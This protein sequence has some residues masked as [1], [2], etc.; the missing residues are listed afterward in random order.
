MNA[1]GG[2]H[3]Q[4]EPKAR[5]N[6]ASALIRVSL[7]EAIQ[8]IAAIE[9]RLHAHVLVEAVDVPKIGPDE[10]GLDAVGWYAGGIQELTVGRTG[11][12][13]GHDTDARKDLRGELLDRTQDLPGHGRRGRAWTPGLQG[14]DLDRG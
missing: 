14:R 10:Q 11:L 4:L 7:D 9:Q 3:G 5:C 8:K 12:Q 2:S 1:R 13:D 6:S